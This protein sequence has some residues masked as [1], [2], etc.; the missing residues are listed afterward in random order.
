[1]PKSKRL[2]RTADGNNA[3]L[4]RQTE[5][6]KDENLREKAGGSGFKLVWQPRSFYASEA[7]F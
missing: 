3:Q 2:L 7:E 1:M 4:M 6:H 5:W